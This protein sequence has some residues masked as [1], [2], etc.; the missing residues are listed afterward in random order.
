[1]E[2]GQRAAVDRNIGNKVFFIDALSD[3]DV[4]AIMA[5]LEHLGV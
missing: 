4:A 5:E 2:R 1:V 3:G